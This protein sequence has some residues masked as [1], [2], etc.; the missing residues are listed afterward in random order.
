MRNKRVFLLDNRAVLSISG[1]DSTDFFNRISTNNIRK[2]SKDKY[3][4][5]WIL[6]PNGR[7][8]YDFF[9]KLDFNSDNTLILDCSNQKKDEILSFYLTILNCER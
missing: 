4:Y 1:S 3:L 7:M 8:L 5:S 6:T 2:V 9:I